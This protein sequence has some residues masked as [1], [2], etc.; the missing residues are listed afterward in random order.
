VTLMRMII[1]MPK[2]GYRHT[3]NQE[4]E[5]GALVPLR[6]SLQRAGVF[7]RLS[8]EVKAPHDGVFIG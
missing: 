2:R 4:L 8:E 7:A 3:T 6:S 1:P 5:L